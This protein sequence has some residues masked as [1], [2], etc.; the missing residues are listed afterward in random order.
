M[1]PRPRFDRRAPVRE[2]PNINDRINYPKLRVV[3]A[4]GT[5]LGVISRD[6]ALDVAKERELDLVLVSE[7]ADPPV[8]RIM[9]YGKFKYEAD[10]RAKE[11]RE[12]SSNL[13][14]KEMK[15][16]PKIGSGDFDTKTKKVEKFLGEGHKVK[17]TIMFRGREMQHPELGRKILENVA[18]E[19]DH[20]GKVEFH[21]R[22]DGRN[23][24]MVLAPDKQ[25]QARHEKERRK[26]E[27]AAN[28]ATVEA[29]APAADEEE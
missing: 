27:A 22:Q 12:K 11:S 29:V 2:L 24:V 8:C 7:K 5:Q 21:P 13:T 25:A 1:A 28:E 10:Q 3:D 17:V 16:R 23:M 6:E 4:D 20:V 19:V 9:D 14:V 15:Y 26:A 18:D